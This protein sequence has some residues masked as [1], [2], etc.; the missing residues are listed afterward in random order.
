MPRK[1][2]LLFTERILEDYFSFYGK[3]I[4]RGLETIKDLYNI[5]ASCT[6]D[7]KESPSI[8][9]VL[10]VELKPRTIH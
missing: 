3:L 8:I 4:T 5:K 9:K 2:F 7:A 1:K 6:N 10:D